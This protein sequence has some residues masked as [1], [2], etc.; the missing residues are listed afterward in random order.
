MKHFVLSV[1]SYFVLTM[2]IAVIW[3]LVLFHAVYK[4]LGAIT[5][6][7][8]IMPFGIMTVFVQALVFSYFY[9]IY[10]RSVGGGHPVKRGIV[11]SLFMGLNVYTVMVFATAAKFQIEPVWTFVA[12]GTVFQLLQF[13]IV[14][15]AIGLVHGRLLGSTTDN[16]AINV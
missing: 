6:D 3:H 9:P 11:Y 12:Y 13:I 14:G 1:I 4:E 5:R 10:Y 2:I 15:I 8:P 7:E 16:S